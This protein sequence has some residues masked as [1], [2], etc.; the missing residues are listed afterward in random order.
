M[1]YILT[2]LL[3]T[4][5]TGAFSQAVYGLITYEE[6]QDLAIASAYS[7]GTEFRSY[8]CK[9]GTVVNVG[10][11][12]IIGSPSTN[13]NQF[14]FIYQGKVSITSAIFVTPQPVA[15]SYQAEEVVIDNIIVYHAKNSKKSV[16][17]MVLYVSNPNFANTLKNR[18]ILDFEKALQLK[19]IHNPNAMTKEVAIAKLKEA[20]ELLDLGVITQS[21]YDSLKAVLSPV[22]TGN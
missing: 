22:I 6:T 7:N 8:K 13:T 15:G 19:E 17:N 10:D 12:L 14:T 11:K 2:A 9:D 4:S 5:A 3:L 1:K 18:T 16:L 21:K 20:K